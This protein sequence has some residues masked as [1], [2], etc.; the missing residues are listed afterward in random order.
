MTIDHD[1]P[2]GKGRFSAAAVLGVLVLVLLAYGGR[3]H[4]VYGSR[5]TTT[6]IPKVS[7]SLSETIINAD[8]VAAL[9]LYEQVRR[10]PL[11]FQAAREATAP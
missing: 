9:P 6:K 5:A 3:F 1:S 4:F 8:E 7:W 2:N 11:F 10:Y